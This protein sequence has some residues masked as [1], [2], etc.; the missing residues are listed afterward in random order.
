MLLLV[1]LFAI[2]KI[3]S[4]FLYVCFKV[5]TPKSVVSPINWNTEGL[6]TEGLK[7]GTKIIN[8]KIT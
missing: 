4:S 6:N 1:I 3:A 5:V 8:M 2:S 7:R